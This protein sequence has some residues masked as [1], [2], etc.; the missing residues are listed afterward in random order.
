[1][2]DQP[3]EDVSADP[4][5]DAQE[6]Q[7]PDVD[8]AAVDEPAFADEPA[9]DQGFAARADVVTGH[10]AV[11]EV[12]RSLDGLDGRPVDEHVAAFE[13]AHEVLRRALSDAGDDTVSREG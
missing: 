7:A 5:D 6:S 3:D 9:A 12:L 1:M 13:Q 4:G 8:E 11:D 2:T 10:P